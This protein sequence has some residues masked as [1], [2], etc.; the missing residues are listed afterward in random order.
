MVI[1]TPDRS[2]SLNSTPTSS[3]CACPVISPVIIGT[4]P[5]VYL[6]AK[7]VFRMRPQP[8]AQELATPVGHEGPLYTE[9]TAGPQE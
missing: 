8:V 1:G 4:L 7:S 9:V 5:L 2:S 6:T 3:G